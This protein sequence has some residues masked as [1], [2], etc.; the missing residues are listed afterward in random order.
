LDKVQL[1]SMK[2]IRF[3][4]AVVS[5]LLNL[6]PP[7]FAVQEKLP[8][9]V[10]GEKEPL[11]LR[12]PVQPSYIEVERKGTVL[13]PEPLTQPEEL[14][15]LNPGLLAV[16]PGVRDLIRG[17]NVSP[18]FKLLYDAKIKLASEGSP[19]GARSYF[20][21]ATVLEMQDAK[22][23]RNV[24]LLQSD[25]DTDTDGTDPVRLPLLKDYDDARSSRSFQPVLAFSWGK[26][27]NGAVNPFPKYF[28]DTLAN[29]RALQREVKGFADSDPGPVWQDMKKH[30]DEQVSLLERR[31]NYFRKDLFSRRSLVASLDPFIVVP[32]T[33]VNS[34]V[35]VGDCA[36]V[37]Y[38]GKAYPCIIGDTGPAEKTGEASQRLARAINPKASGNV[39]AVTTPAVTYLIFPG[40]RAL[41]SEP[42]LAR[43]CAEV[44]QLLGE[45]GGLG[46]GVTLHEWIPKLQNKY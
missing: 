33:W 21:C 31:A 24:L 42:D 28:E 22:S 7:A 23:G 44:K 1:M 6:A 14:E 26:G 39:S 16:L 45:I 34:H 38:G 12:N 36:A 43:C 9:W 4:F 37:V 27:A 29:L 19:L 5:L 13:R 3:H 18:K 15:K 17:A 2:P 41:L 32:K 25:M 20:D 8:D 40:T 46:G 11:P 30:F 35:G 10:V